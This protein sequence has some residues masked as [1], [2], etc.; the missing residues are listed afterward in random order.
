MA[1][2]AIDLLIDAVDHTPPRK[3][4]P[5]SNL[6]G[7]SVRD[8]MGHA[9]GSA[10]KMVTLPRKR[11]VWGGPSQPADWVCDDPAGTAS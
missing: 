3:L 10:A 9:T 1:A 4:G 8:L 5:P 7:W 6:E 11:D 2:E